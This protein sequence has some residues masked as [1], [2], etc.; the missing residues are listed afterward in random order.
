MQE[1]STTIIPNAFP[2][3]A[4]HVETSEPER[5]MEQLTTEAERSAAKQS[6]GAPTKV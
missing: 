5:T 1:G 3:R 4:P 2:H 6:T